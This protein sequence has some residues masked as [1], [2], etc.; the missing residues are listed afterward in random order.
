MPVQR[1]TPAFVFAGILAA[2]A[3]FPLMAAIRA[4][5]EGRAESPAG[6]RDHRPDL[7]R[8]PAGHLQLV[9]GLGPVRAGALLAERTRGGAF[10]DFDE[11]ARR[12]HGI[13]RTT[14]ERMR[15][16]SEL[17]R[18]ASEIDAPAASAVR[19]Q[20]GERLD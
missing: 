14:V 8:S 9:P 16:W 11:I 20:Q 3:V 5:P 19:R 7:N 17:G 15:G 13:G 1:P 6:L 10:R 2:C 18:T 4:E 12:V